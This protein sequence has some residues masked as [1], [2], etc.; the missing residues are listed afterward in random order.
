MRQ[1]IRLTQ[2]QRRGEE[3]EGGQEMRVTYT[4]EVSSH[5]NRYTCSFLVT[6]SPFLSPVITGRDESR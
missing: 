3:R 4:R 6:I 2:A 5:L 1:F